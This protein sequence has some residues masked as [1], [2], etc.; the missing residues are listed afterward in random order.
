MKNIAP[1]LVIIA[2]F[3]WGIIGI[4]SKKLSES[5][6]NPIQITE[7][8]CLITA[9]VLLIYL[10]ISDRKKLIINIKDIWLFFGTGILSIAFFNI[11]YFTAIEASSLSSAAILLYTAPFFVLILSAIF[12]KERLSLKKI[13]A[14][15]IAFIGCSLA[16]GLA[17][18][19]TITA[20]GLI[21]GIL[22]GIGYGLYSI[23]SRIALKKYHTLT[24][25]V[26]T[27]IT[28]SIA[29]LPFCNIGIMINSLSK[30]PNCILFAAALALISTLTPFLCYTKGLSE[31]DTGTAAIIAYLEPL[32]ATT[33]GIL[34]FKE[35]INVLK[36]T[37]ISLIL[38][39]II[40][41]NFRRNVKRKIDKS[42]KK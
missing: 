35:E 9:T 13:T 1:I 22:S 19:E 34:L 24:I 17:G 29:L 7:T 11:C 36:I 12:F 2:G 4:F 27:F 39:S 10:L 30:N 21:Y 8:R 40:I 18:G 20:K 37:G 41:L 5:G 28:A 26:Y 25:T 42:Y 33:C 38:L 23:F 32:V 16:V 14:L 3:C 31:M 15:I 6:F